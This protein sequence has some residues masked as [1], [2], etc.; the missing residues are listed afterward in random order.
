MPGEMLTNYTTTKTGGIYLTNYRVALVERSKKVVANIPILSIDEVHDIGNHFLQ[1]NCKSGRIY[2]YIRNIYSFFLSFVCETYPRRFIVP[3]DLSDQHLVEA[4]GARMLYR[5]PA[6]VWYSKENE[7][8]LIRCSQ[9]WQNFFMYRSQQ[10]EQTLK[11]M[12]SRHSEKSVKEDEK[13]GLIYGKG[14]SYVSISVA[15]Y[16][17]PAEVMFAGLPNI[18]AVRN[19]FADLRAIQHK[20]VLKSYLKKVSCLNSL[21]FIAFVL[22]WCSI[23]IKKFLETSVLVHCSD[24]WD[25]TAQVTTL[26]KIIADP[27]FRTIEG[28]EFLIRRDW[29]EFGHKFADRSGLFNNKNEQSPIFLQWLDCVHQILHK[30]PAAFEFTQEYLVKLALHTYSGL[31]G[32]FLFNSL[33]QKVQIFKEAGDPDMF[34]IWAYLRANTNLLN[35]M[36]I[37]PPDGKGSLKVDPRGLRLWIEVYGGPSLER[38][39][40]APYESFCKKRWNVLQNSL[41]MRD[42]F[43]FS[44]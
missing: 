27:Y 20:R 16:Y 7:T 43:V 21:S 40:T 25:R 15:D 23:S 10:D 3:S 38:F 30:F 35:V 37:P 8:V 17:S 39:F 34:S 22:Q 14:N 19:N 1:I 2:R 12:R 33:K 9:P 13:Q 41:Q 28:F 32:T 24:G 44:I 5:F 36:Y 18:H 42:L 11:A 29:I 6:V 31:F 26:A 4:A